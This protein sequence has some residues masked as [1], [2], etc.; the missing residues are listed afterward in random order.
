MG[1]LYDFILF[2][3]FNQRSGESLPF[4]PADFLSILFPCSLPLEADLYGYFGFQVG[5]NRPLAGDGREEGH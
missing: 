4:I 2:F 3:F 5:T 1:V